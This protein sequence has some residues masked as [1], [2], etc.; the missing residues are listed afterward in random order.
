LGLENYKTLL[1]EMR[2]LNKWKEILCSWLGKLN[3][4]KIAI[5][6]KTMFKF[7]AIPIKIQWFF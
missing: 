2:H 4:V 7:T 5:I 6:Y 1:G 3:I